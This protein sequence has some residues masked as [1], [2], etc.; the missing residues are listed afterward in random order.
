MPDLTNTTP[1]LRLTIELVPETCWYTNLRQVLPPAQWDRLRRE[2]YRRFGYHCAVCGAGGKLHCHEVWAYDDATH[3]QSLQGFRALCEN[4]HHIKHLGFAGILAGRGQ[5][6]YDQLI[7]HFCSVNGCDDQT[8]ERHR[9]AAFA[10]WRERSRHEWQTDLGIDV[11]GG[12][13]A[14]PAVPG[15]MLQ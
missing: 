2:V 4:C 15:E 11:L 1:S 9:A 14:P 3:V 8:F 10:E 12:S 7:A 13:G 6:D 5:L